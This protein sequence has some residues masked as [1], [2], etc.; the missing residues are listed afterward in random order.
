MWHR[1]HTYLT[2]ICP[3]KQTV[4][5]QIAKAQLISVGIRKEGKGEGERERGRKKRGEERGREGKERGGEGKGREGERK[6][7]G[8][9]GRERVSKWEG[10]FPWGRDLNGLEVKQKPY[11]KLTYSYF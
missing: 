8:G 11:F 9:E 4:M 7:R 6:G 5:E 1:L 10:I 2:L 3:Q